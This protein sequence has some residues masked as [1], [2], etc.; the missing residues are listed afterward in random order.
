MNLAREAANIV[1]VTVPYSTP[2]YPDA[3]WT[4]RTRGSAPLIVQMPAVRK[5][6]GIVLYLARLSIRQLRERAG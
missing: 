3:I 1:T 5:T 6:S 4:I 2:V